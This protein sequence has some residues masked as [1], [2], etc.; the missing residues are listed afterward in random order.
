MIIKRILEQPL[1]KKLDLFGAVL[2]SGPKYC[3]KTFLANL[4]SKSSFIFNDIS[5][6]DFY[7]ANSEYVLNGPYPKLIDEWQLCPRVWDNVR[8]KID[9]TK[10]NQGMFILTGSS[11]PLQTKEVFHTGAGRID[12]IR[13]G[14][15]TF[16]EM[17]D[18]NEV[19]SISLKDLFNKKPIDKTISSNVDFSQVLN[20]LINGGW[21]IIFDKEL[22]DAKHISENYV[23]SIIHLEGIKESNLRVVPNTFKK[24]MRSI[25]RRIGTQISLDSAWKDVTEFSSKST[26]LKYVQ[27]M[28]DSQMLFNVDVWGNDNIRSKYKIRTTPKTYMCD[29]SLICNIL[30]VTSESDFSKDANSLG[31]IFE[32]Q[33]MKD[34]STYA[35][36]LGAKLYFYRDEKGN[37]IDAILEMND[38]RWAAIEIKLSYSSALGS[39]ERL[40][41]VIQTMKM[42]GREKDP[43]FKMIICTGP[44]VGIKDDVLIIPHTLLRP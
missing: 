32:N 13:L 35:I 16:A 20:F 24:I 40:N 22:K 21:P 5:S 26:F 8:V 25:T 4:C 28:Y 39:T 3:G 7:I 2:I 30:E 37:E 23:E 12:Q 27:V 18:L 31:F 11:S 9:S 38:G 6:I 33:V 41:H 19:N 44:T 29:T 34:L 36:A 1:Q 43:T 17:L 42:E 14:T 15:L 10:D